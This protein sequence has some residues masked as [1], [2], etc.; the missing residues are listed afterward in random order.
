MARTLRCSDNHR[1]NITNHRFN[2]THGRTEV[3]SVAIHFRVPVIQRWTC[4]YTSDRLWKED[5][6]YRKIEKADGSGPWALCGP[7]ERIYDQTL[8]DHFAKPRLVSTTIRHL[9]D[10]SFAGC[11]PPK[12]NKDFTFVY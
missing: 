2:I 8:S 4:R 7:V 3:S 6:I 12:F 10:H 5:I 1:F 11:V 9:A